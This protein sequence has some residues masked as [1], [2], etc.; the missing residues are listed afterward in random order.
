[1][2]V[3]L[4]ANDHYR[5]SS[6]GSH[7]RKI[8]DYAPSSVVSSV[9]SS[10]DA[11]HDYDA[12][13]TNQ[14]QV[15]LEHLE[16]F[17]YQENNILDGN[18][19][20]QEECEEWASLFP[21]LRIRGHQT[22]PSSDIG[23][24]AI[25]RNELRCHS[26]YFY[27]PESSS[28]SHRYSQALSQDAL[29]VEGIGLGSDIIGQK[30]ADRPIAEASP[31]VDEHSLLGRSMFSW[32]DSKT[33][34]ALNALKK[35]TLQ[36]SGYQWQIFGYQPSGAEGEDGTPDG[37]EEDRCPTPTPDNPHPQPI[38]STA[39]KRARWNVEAVSAGSGSFEVLKKALSNLKGDGTRNHFA[40]L[41]HSV[42]PLVQPQPQ[43]RG[44]SPD[45]GVSFVSWA[46]IGAKPDG[47]TQ[48]HDET[49]FLTV[50]DVLPV[51]QNVNCAIYEY[52]SPT[53]ENL[54]AVSAQLFSA[55]VS[56]VDDGCGSW[57]N[58]TNEEV[59][60]AD[61]EVE[62]W[63]ASENQ[64]AEDAEDDKQIKHHSHRRRALPPVTPNASI[65]QDILGHLFDD[66]W[67]EM[68]P[69]F[70]PLLNALSDEKGDE[71]DKDDDLIDKLPFD[72]MILRELADDGL[73]S[74]MTIRPVSLQKRDHSAPRPKASADGTVY[75][76]PSMADFYGAFSSSSRPA[77]ARP[78]S[79]R[80]TSGRHH[81]DVSQYGH[82]NH[83]S[84][85]Q[86]AAQS[87]NKASYNWKRN[88]P[89]ARL[90][91]LP[92]VSA[93]TSV[94]VISTT[95]TM[96]DMIYGTSIGYG[97]TKSAATHAWDSSRP[98]TSIPGSNTASKRLP[99]IRGGTVLHSQDGIDGLTKQST[100]HVI[101]DA[102]DAADGPM[103]RLRPASP[104][105]FSARRQPSAGIRRVRPHTAIVID[106]SKM[107]APISRTAAKPIPRNN[108]GHNS[109]VSLYGEERHQDPS[110]PVLG[111]RMRQGVKSAIGRR[112]VATNVY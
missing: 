57:L 102:P 47:V 32:T 63:I 69:V 103:Q 3:L 8:F 84:R 86:S 108:H 9:S 59:F 96:N 85:M 21:H 49:P 11:E 56:L 14:V 29:N 6:Q 68:V 77:S 100:R 15:M 81:G 99:P 26:P 1:M 98:S 25:P 80:P 40:L 65:R 91:P 82:Q 17:L 12:E 23:Y 95:N 13:A 24:E 46:S 58:E 101:F 53:L 33:S 74:A 112:K 44:R 110:N 64:S 107:T 52:L 19:T 41:K 61:G 109:S 34:D 28:A 16:T 87:A 76:A 48:T 2:N 27:I 38:H 79:A 94:N 20:L 62:E 39:A 7:Q 105:P 22:L 5:Q 43:H 75:N 36:T 90:L 10:W 66:I 111:I 70:Q 37:D 73:L 89:G 45:C 93:N 18:P 97:Q 4:N 35:G 42:H 78:T 50:Y 104:R 88:N 30:H 92:A 72:D 83:S 60:A 54:L 55:S 67:S 106:E 51:L 31:A 71:D